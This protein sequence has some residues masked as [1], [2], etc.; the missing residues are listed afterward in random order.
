MLKDNL[1][2]INEKIK[3]DFCGSNTFLMYHRITK[4]DDFKT[5]C[6]MSFNL[7]CES[8]EKIGEFID[9]YSALEFDKSRKHIITFDD[10]TDDIYSIVYPF[11]TEKNIPFTVFI[12]AQWL[13]KEGYITTEQLAE[14][15]KNSLVTIGSHGLSHSDLKG[16]PYNEQ[17]KELFESKL[18]LE[19]II[20]KKVSLFAYPHGQSDSS[21]L[22]I[23]KSENLYSYC[24]NASGGGATKCNG[25]FAIPRLRVDNKSYKKTMALLG[26]G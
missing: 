6:D 25:C 16:M 5:G 11:L 10:A 18:I 8:I 21:T 7:F 26:K 12:V 20:Q 3:K 19:N 22:K 14:I 23:L 13:D 17:K 2:I 1:R 24:F 4:L 9:S 15:S